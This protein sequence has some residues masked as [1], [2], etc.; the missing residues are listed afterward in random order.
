MYD[1][2]ELRWATDALW[3]AIAA[4]VPGAPA[5]LARGRALMDVWT[6][7]ALLLAQ[8]CGYPLVTSLAGKVR[9]VAVPRYR[10]AGCAGILY[11]SA[12]I[13]RAD[14]PA[15]CLADLRGRR[16]AVNGAESNSGMNVLRAAIAPLAERAR[17]FGSVIMTGA[18]DA[19]VGAVARGDADVAAIDCVT[20]AQLQRLRPGAVAGL[21]VL[22]WTAATSGLPLITSVRTDSATRDRLVR[23]LDDV[24]AD[25]TLA[26][27]RDTLLIDGFATVPLGAYDAVLDLEKRAFELGYG[28][29]K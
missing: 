3:A 11:R 19:S 28:A 15:A 24:V 2:P 23:A 26:P 8:T 12:V 22:A 4:R 9:L 21:R 16:C 29:L 17:F 10:A 7:P 1:F 5:R 18:H 6:D 20:W 25:V 13:V 14:E 27:V